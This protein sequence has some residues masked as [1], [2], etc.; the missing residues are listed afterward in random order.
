MNQIQ[1]EELDFYVRKFFSYPMEQA[2]VG[3]KIR[4]VCDTQDKIVEMLETYPRMGQCY[5]LGPVNEEQ[6][7]LLLQKFKNTPY[8]LLR[9]IMRENN[10]KSQRIFAHVYIK[11]NQFI[12]PFVF[13]F[14]PDSFEYPDELIDIVVRMK[15]K[16]I[17]K[18]IGK[19]KSISQEQM[20]EGLKCQKDPEIRSKLAELYRMRIEEIEK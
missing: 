15:S 3:K 5:S 4:Q 18:F 11:D 13:D 1:K 12:R 2:Y 17:K 10:F 16:W 6:V 19:I 9:N 14:L 8:P 7:Y 20:L